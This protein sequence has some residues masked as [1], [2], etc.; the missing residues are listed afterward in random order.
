MKTYNQLNLLPKDKDGCHLDKWYSGRWD[1]P[2]VSMSL[3]ILFLFP[4]PIKSSWAHPAALRGW[5]APRPPFS[6]HF[7]IPF[8][9]HPFPVLSSGEHPTARRLV[10]PLF[11]IVQLKDTHQKPAI[12]GSLRLGPRLVGTSRD[13]QMDRSHWKNTT[14]KIQHNVTLSENRAI[15]FQQALDI[16]TQQKHKKITLNPIL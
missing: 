15:L 13:N 11:S 5:L 8:L 16:L 9:P 6:S 10:P 1:Y 12:S 2:W 3:K 7:L 14:N 4:L